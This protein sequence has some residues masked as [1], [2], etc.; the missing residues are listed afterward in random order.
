MDFAAHKLGHELGGKF[1]ITHGA[2]LTIMWP[3]WAE[4]VWEKAP[5]R[6]ARLGRTV[7]GLTDGED[8]A[9]A[10]GAVAAF[11]A[12]F[13]ELGLPV[14]FGESPIGVEQPQ[15]LELF[16]DN[17]TDGKT[18]GLGNLC[19]LDYDGILKVYQSANH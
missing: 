13:R 9:A 3:A 17:C 19:A 1:N 10:R 15:V 11:A 18:H 16:A 12:Y 2:S 6:F 7:F 4:C 8:A 14:C 5:E